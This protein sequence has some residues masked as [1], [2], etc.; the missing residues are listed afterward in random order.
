MA[1][2][3][4]SIAPPIAAWVDT[5]LKLRRGREAADAIIEFLER[6]GEAAEAADA[7]YLP[8]LTTRM[9]FRAVTLREPG[10]DRNLLEYVTF[11]VPAGSR[12]A[13]VGSDPVEKRSLGYRIPR[14]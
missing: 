1:V 2:A 5:R 11:A 3:L 9:E 6:R 14:F 12:V 10:T 4:V 13:I 7:E 8:A